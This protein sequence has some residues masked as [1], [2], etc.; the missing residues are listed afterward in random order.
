M[1]NYVEEIQKKYYGKLLEEYG[2]NY[3]AVSSETKEHKKLRYNNLLKI[4]DCNQEF[5]IHDVGCGIGNL[6][7]YMDEN[8]KDHHFIYSGSEIV[9]EFYDYCREAYPGNKFF[10]R[11]IADKSFEDKYDYIVLSGIFH[12]MRNISIK[13]WEEFYRNLIKNSFQMSK[14][15]IAFNFVTEFVD[16]YQP[17]IYYCNINKLINFINDNLSRF[18]VINHSYPLYELTVFVY[19]EAFIKS[20]YKEIEFEKYF[21]IDN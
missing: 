10:L 18:F 9:K 7:E 2:Y 1:N 21:K 17:G 16:F 3:K 11:N 6:L 4:I 19:K 8:L 20:K 12:Q 13:D 5:S 15:G 14:K